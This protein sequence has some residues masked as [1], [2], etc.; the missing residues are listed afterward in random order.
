MFLDFTLNMGWAFQLVE[1]DF[2]YTKNGLGRVIS[3]WRAFAVNQLVLV[4]VE[5]PCWLTY[6]QGLEPFNS[7]PQFLILAGVGPV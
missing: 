7:L 4:K 5:C 3:F 1:G 6:D 2:V